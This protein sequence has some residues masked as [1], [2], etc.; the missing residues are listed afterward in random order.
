MLITIKDNIKIFLKKYKYFW[1]IKKIYDFFIKKNSFY[2]A[3]QSI[4]TNIELRY[5][6]SKLEK[7]FYKKVYSNDFRNFFK[8]RINLDDENAIRIR[9]RGISN[10]FLVESFLNHKE[11]IKDYFYTQKFFSDKDPNKKYNLNDKANLKVGYFS[12]E[13]TLKCPHIFEIANDEKIINTLAS[14]F[15]CP[16]KLDYITSWWSFKNPG[17]IDEKTQYFHRDLDNFNFIKMFLYLTDVDINKGAHQYV[18][19]S[20]KDTYNLKISRSVIDKND[21]NFDSLEVFDFVGKS[22]SA[23]LADTFGLHRG[24]TPINGDRL[25]IVFSYSVKNSIHSID[26]RNINYSIRE[27]I[28]DNNFNKYLN[29]NFIGK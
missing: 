4:I 14:Y 1:I 22:G 23:L 24:S 2:H 10:Q 17:N 6:F 11:K 20:H 25:M 29:K 19:G 3:L 26:K 27:K 5:N 15:Q 28:A 16:F 9:Q 18:V 21:L 7:F 12:S 8:K 13:V